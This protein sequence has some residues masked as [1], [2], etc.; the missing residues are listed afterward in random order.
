MPNSLCESI[1]R[2]IEH[3]VVMPAPIS[4]V[5]VRLIVWQHGEDVKWW[6]HT[7]IIQIHEA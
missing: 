6:P 2:E 3:K 5:Y 7:V 4:G 1:T